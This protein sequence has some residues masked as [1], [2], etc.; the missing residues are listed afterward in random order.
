MSLLIL[1][2]TLF[3]LDAASSAR[4]WEF[5]PLSFEGTSSDPAKLNI[6]LAIERIKR[7]EFAM[8]GIIDC[9]YDM[10]E[11]T[12]V[13]GIFLRSNT[14]DEDDYKLM[15]WSIPKQSFKAFVASYYENVALKNV[16]YCSNLPALENADPWPRDVYKFENCVYTGDGL[17]EVAPEGFYKV[18]FIFTGEVEWTFT[19][20][21]KVTLKMDLYG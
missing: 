12:M 19:A 18:T 10:D 21:S 6:D 2:L 13:E 3:I 11:T 5:E 4:L 15:P 17:P 14:G 9:K 16:G 8:N 1:A 7:G 20:K